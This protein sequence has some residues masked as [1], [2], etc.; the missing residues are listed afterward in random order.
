MDVFL[1]QC[2]TPEAG[3]HGAGVIDLLKWIMTEATAA[4]GYAIYVRTSTADQHG[5]AQL[6]AL[7]KAASAR[8]WTQVREFVD[9]GHSGAKASR[10]A[11]DELKAAVR[12]GEICQVMTFALDRLGRSLRDLLLLIDDLAAGG[13]AVISLREGLDLSTATG[14]LMLQVFGA[15][16][17]FERAIITERVR[18]GIARV[19][20]TGKTRSGKA[21]GRPRREVDLLTVTRLRGEGRTWRQVAQSMKVPRKTLER[22]FAATLGQNPPAKMA[23]APAGA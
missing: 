14:R 18:S 10:P 8:V 12:R 22:A 6:H 16:A 7:R 20:A 3:C 5:E 9:L 15:L 19:Q 13:C 23:S 4:S 1:F 11:L 2:P 17:E 21:I